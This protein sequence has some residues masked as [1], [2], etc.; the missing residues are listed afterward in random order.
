MKIVRIRFSNEEVYGFSQEN[1][2]PLSGRIGLYFIFLPNLRIPYPFK[3][4]GLV[5]VGMSESRFNSIGNRL[6]EHYSGKSQNRGILGYKKR[7]DIKFTY[8][9][10]EF[11]KHVFPDERIEAME[12]VFLEAFASV[13][14][15]F[16]ICNNR[17]GDQSISPAK[18]VPEID[19]DFFAKRQEQ[20]V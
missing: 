20:R 8:L 9:D 18:D 16:P 12:A 11:L 2:P 17:R 5:Y 1:F 19:W 10:F 6:K 15:S 7:G 14:G 13:H 3:D 4:S